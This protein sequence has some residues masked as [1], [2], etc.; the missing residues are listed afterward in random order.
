MRQNPE[1]YFVAIIGIILGLLLVGFIVAMLVLYKR[2]QQKQEQ[3]MIMMKDRYEKEVLQS[4]L[5]IQENTFKTISQELHDNIGQMLSV[6]KLSLSALPI[7]KDH[8]A[9]PLVTH[10]QQVLQKAIFDLSDLTKSLHTD[11]ITDLGLVESVRFELTAIKNTGALEVELEV[12]GT[13]FRLQGQKEIVLFRMFQEML[14]NILKHSKATR[15]DVALTYRQENIFVM[16]IEDNGTGFDLEEK[17]SS[18]SAGVGLKSLFNRAKLIGA[19]MHIET[20]L[21]KGTHI[22]V[23]LLPQA[24]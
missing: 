14:H 22:T 16:K 7:D 24:N 21:N 3:E 20:G 19:T 11:R 17:R 1:M 4:Q 8:R 18:P 2:R 6:V 13:E 5:E 9:R 10:S 12:Q 23:E 15:V